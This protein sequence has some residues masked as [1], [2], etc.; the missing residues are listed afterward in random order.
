MTQILTACQQAAYAAIV[1]LITSSQKE[2]VITGPAGCGKTTLI[3]TFM[4]EWPQ[5]VAISGGMYKDIDIHLTATTNKAADALSAATNKETTTIHSLLG[6]R[7]VSTGFR[8]SNLK[9][10]GKP[11]PD[12]LII[13]DEASFIDASLLHK[14]RQKAKG[15]KV[16]FLGDP[17]QLKPVGSDNTPVFDSGITTVKLSQ[18]VR[19]ADNSPIQI[20]SKALRDHVAGAPMPKAGVDGISI[21]HMQ[22]E[23]FEASLIEDCRTHAGNAVRA[24][25]WTNQTAIGYNQMVSHALSG[26]SEIKL[27]DTV[28]VNKQIQK[29]GV[30]KL[31]T[32]STVTVTAVGQWKKD[33]YDIFSRAVELNGHICIRQAKNITDTYAAIKQAYSEDNPSKAHDIENG[34]ADLR[35]MYASTVNKAQGSTYD[36]VYINLTDI[37]KCRDQDQVKRM[38]YVAVSRARTKVVF[39]GDL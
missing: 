17:C 29:R 20:L 5:F 26:N 36:T 8:E 22:K 28:V 32:D 12:G 6:L 38:I 15:N 35:L 39:T 27:G 23:E 7:V 11:V 16:I 9:D 33:A 21:F 37:G 24:L 18:I 4:K 34:Y 14:I 31:P 2:L 13:I 1:T 3:D 25:A 10:T 19:Q 30:Y